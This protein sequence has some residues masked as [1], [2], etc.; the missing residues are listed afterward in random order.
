MPEFITLAEMAKREE[1][2]FIAEQL[3]KLSPIMQFL[4]FERCPGGVKKYAVREALPT[5]GFRGINDTITPS[6]SVVN[7]YQEGC[8]VLENNPWID[9][10]AITGNPAAAMAD[11][12]MASAEV[13]KQ[14]FCDAF[15]YGDRGVNPKA[16]DGLNTRILSSGGQFVSAAGSGSDTYSVW[17]LA[18]GP[19][20]V[21]GI[22]PK[23]E[24]YLDARMIP[25]LQKHET[26]KTMG[27][28]G[29]AFF[30]A[31]IA[32]VSPR[33]LCQY[34]NIKNAGS[35]NIFD[36]DQFDDALSRVDNPTMVVMPRTG[37]L[38]FQKK[39]RAAVSLRRDELGRWFSDYG[40]LPI[41]I[42]ENLLTTETN[43]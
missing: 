9:R 39:A 21:Q 16:F 3:N 37:F 25:G 33:A 17:I 7:P 34:G 31:G 12:L 8:A 29:H 35:S 2:G 14:T 38:Q 10:A 41:Y 43:K 40:G 32:V 5:I 28:L 26:K 42:D 13:I 18:L 4:P 30:K 1:V 11:E 36:L 23:D 19:N 24:D 27:Y 15:F 22:I 20:K 6:V